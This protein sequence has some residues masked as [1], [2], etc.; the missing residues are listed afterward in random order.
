MNTLLSSTPIE[1]SATALS[2]RLQ[3]GPLNFA[4]IVELSEKC[5]LRVPEVRAANCRNHQFTFVV[6]GIQ[7]VASIS[8]FVE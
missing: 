4:E 6:P 8:R 2:K 7:A 3:E 5:H 1:C